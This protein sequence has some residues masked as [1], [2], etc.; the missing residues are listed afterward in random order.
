MIRPTLVDFIDLIIRRSELSLSMEEFIV[1]KDSR[2]MDRN[3]AQCDIRKKANVIVVAIKKPGEEID[4]NPSPSITI[5]LGDT[6]L[7]L[8]NNEDIN[9]FENTYIGIGE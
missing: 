4:F 1:N 7:V 9:Q 3:L 8:G 6:L 2:I 5:E